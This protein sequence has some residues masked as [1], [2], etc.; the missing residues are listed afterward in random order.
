LTFL[1][2]K[3]YPAT[4]DTNPI[5]PCKRLTRIRDQ[6]D[7]SYDGSFRG[8]ISIASATEI[9]HSTSILDVLTSRDAYRIPVKLITLQLY[10]QQFSDRIY[11]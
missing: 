3:F 2:P 5:S 4:F 9:S 7:I 8:D 11:K 6:D 10:Q 1:H